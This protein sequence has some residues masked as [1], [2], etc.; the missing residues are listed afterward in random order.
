[1]PGHTSKIRDRFVSNVLRGCRATLREYPA[2]RK[3][4]EILL[5]SFLH[6]AAGISPIIKNVPA[7]YGTGINLFQKQPG[8]EIHRAGMKP[9]YVPEIYLSFGILP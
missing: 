8:Y 4:R 3:I 2:K 5:N 7:S 9:L 6:R 1:L